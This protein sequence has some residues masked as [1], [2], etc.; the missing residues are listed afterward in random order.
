MLLAF[1]DVSEASWQFPHHKHFLALA[2]YLALLPAPI[3]LRVLANLL[4]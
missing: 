2:V 1:P 4:E 3:V